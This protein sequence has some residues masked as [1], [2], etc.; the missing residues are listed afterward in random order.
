MLCQDPGLA[1]KMEMKQGRSLCLIH[2][3]P[4]PLWHLGDLCC[5]SPPRWDVTFTLLFLSQLPGGLRVILLALAPH[6]TRSAVLSLYHRAWKPPD[7]ISESYET[8]TR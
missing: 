5:D 1:A 3:K 2:A 4:Q 7:R 6:P 8:R